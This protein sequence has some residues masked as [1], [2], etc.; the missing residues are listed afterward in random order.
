[1]RQ[2]FGAS[3]GHVFVTSRL[4]CV[5]GS[6]Q[7]FGVC[8]AWSGGEGCRSES[9]AGADVLPDRPTVERVGESGLGCRD[10]VR[11]WRGSAEPDADLA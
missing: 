4:V 8:G 10:Y 5:F 2:R 1:M 9:S 3:N 11:D 7:F 6:V